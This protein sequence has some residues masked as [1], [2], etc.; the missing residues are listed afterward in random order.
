[1]ALFRRQPR[2]RSARPARPAHQPDGITVAD[3]VR[4][5]QAAYDRA[6]YPWPDG[7]TDVV[8]PLIERYQH[9]HDTLLVLL[10]KLAE[11]NRGWAAYGAEQLMWDAGAGDSEHPA[12]NR[13]MDAS[14]NFLRRSGVPPTRVTEAEWRRWREFGETKENWLMSRPVPP[15]G[16]ISELAA[17]E[18][19]RVV[20]LTERASS[21]VYLVEQGADGRYNWIIDA[22]ESGGDSGRTEW[23]PDAADTLHRLY[24]KISSSLQSVP[25]W[26]DPEF[27]PYCPWR[28]PPV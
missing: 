21:N 3:L 27:E 15:E 23:V 1:M 4:Y 12:R 10:A 18:K 7:W 22:A 25:F 19:R 16:R 26:C 20:Q 6:K 9:R 5:G 13:I 8:W 28:H 2:P 24:I 11:Q 14:I 17:D